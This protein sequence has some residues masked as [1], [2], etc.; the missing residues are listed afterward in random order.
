MSLLLCSCHASL[1]EKAN[2]EHGTERLCIYLR[3]C[4]TCDVEAIA[5]NLQL[6]KESLL[7]SLRVVLFNVDTGCRLEGLVRWRRK[8]V[9][10]E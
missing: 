10:S 9:L 7:K 6:G 5:T 2:Q 3:D 1:P 8:P 4:L